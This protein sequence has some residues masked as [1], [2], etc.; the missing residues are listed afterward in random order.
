MYLKECGGGIMSLKEIW[1]STW[2]AND[3]YYCR[4]KKN[5]KNGK[6]CGING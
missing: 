5:E 1:A 6:E 2:I 3:R 4:R